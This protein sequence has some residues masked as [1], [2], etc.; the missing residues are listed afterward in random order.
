[1][2]EAGP[3][4]YASY[5]N[6]KQLTTSFNPMK[7]KSVVLVL[8]LTSLASQV[9]AGEAFTAQWICQTCNG[10]YVIGPSFPDRTSCE[11]FLA[12]LEQRTSQPLIDAKC[13]GAQRH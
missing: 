11:K 8:L 2:I 1:M 10:R 7:I 12:Q 5:A 6:P 4:A 9:Q 13:V 3:S